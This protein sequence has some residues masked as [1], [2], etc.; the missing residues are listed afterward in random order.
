MISLISPA[1][2]MKF[3]ESKR[4]VGDQPFFLDRSVIIMEK[5]K[6][7]SANRLEKLMG[8]NKELAQLNLE[9]N[10]KWNPNNKGNESEA[11]LFAFDGE[12]YRGLDAE[13]LNGDDLEFA[14]HHLMI[15]SGL[16]G[17]LKPFD[18]VQP[19]RLEMGSALKIGRKGTQ[20]AFILQEE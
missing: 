20:G 15:L 14:N 8:I 10:R 18:V 13:S 5:L 7:L 2:T 19:Y 17:L 1:K 11:A 16:Y 9:R 6:S 12:V 4:T 3:A